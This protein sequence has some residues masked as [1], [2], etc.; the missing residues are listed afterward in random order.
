MALLYLFFVPLVEPQGDAVLP[1]LESEQ[2][3]LAPVS[4]DGARRQ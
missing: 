2:T 4:G 3:V 1:L